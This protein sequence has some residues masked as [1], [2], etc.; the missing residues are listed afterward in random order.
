MGEKGKVFV[1]CGVCGVS[2]MCVVY[3]WVER[4]RLSWCL[5]TWCMFNVSGVFVSGK[6]KVFVVYELR[7][8]PLTGAVYL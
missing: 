8:A 3:V 5:A 2:V 7:G 4:V 1:I 6:G